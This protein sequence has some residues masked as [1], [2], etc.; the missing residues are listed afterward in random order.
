M[1]KFV[2]LPDTREGDWGGVHINSGIPNK[3]FY[4][5]AMTIGGFA[6]DEAGQIWYEALLASNRNTQ[7][8]DFADNTYIQA[9]QMYGTRSS[10][11]QAVTEAWKEVG[12]R[13]RTRSANNRISTR[14]RSGG[15]SDGDS[16]TA[17]TSQI[18]ALAT[19]VKI[20]SKDVNLLKD[21]R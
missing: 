13:I 9:G 1:S 8:Q 3:A 16:L 21:K 4:L 7:F 17:L 11:Q 2:V 5:T 6:W 19:Q 12:I 14:G 15:T 20:L 10:Q 18:E